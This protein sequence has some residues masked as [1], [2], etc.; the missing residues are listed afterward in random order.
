VQLPGEY[1]AP[2][3]AL[4]LVLGTSRVAG[5]VGLRPLSTETAEIKRLYVAPSERGTGH[6]R[7][8]LDALIAEAR[9]LGYQHLV[10]ETL[11]AM[12]AARALYAAYG[13]VA[14]TLYRDDAGDTTGVISL[15]LSLAADAA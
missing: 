11:D 2:R 14:H 15:R 13:F 12:Q 9:R 5:C 1:A 4:L 10:L 6:A 3:G 8:L 7:A